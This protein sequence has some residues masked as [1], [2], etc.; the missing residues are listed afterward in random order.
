MSGGK[1]SY[2]CPLHQET[3]PSFIVYT[4]GEYEK[5]YCF[6]CNAKLNII[7]LVASL[8][9]ISWKKA[10]E[11]LS[12]GI[13]ITIDGSINFSKEEVSKFQQEFANEESNLLSGLEEAMTIISMHC[14]DYL[15]T[16]NQNPEECEMVDKFY[17]LIDKK[18]LDCEFD[19]IEE[20][21]ENLPIVLKMRLDKFEAKELEKLKNVSE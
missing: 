15:E 11:L 2:C 20:M 18:M 6:G 19:K 9:N 7:D 8:E 21:S 14:K 10:V 4:Y 13:E 5:F 12:D 1:V 16:V 17:A 3:K